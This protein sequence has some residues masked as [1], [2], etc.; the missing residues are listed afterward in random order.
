MFKTPLNR[1]DRSV[2]KYKMS[3]VTSGIR[4]K[5][6]VSLYTIFPRYTITIPLLNETLAGTG[7][8]WRL[9]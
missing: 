4:E 9:L 2:I 3:L 7:G 1:Q 6:L 8:A 5:P